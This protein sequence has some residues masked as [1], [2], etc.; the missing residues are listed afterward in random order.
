MYE[1]HLL[2]RQGFTQKE[3][4]QKLDVSDRTVRNYLS[5][6]PCRRKKAARCSKLS[7]FQ[8][9]IQSVIKDNPFF[10]NILLFQKIQAMGY[11][12]KLTI[13][14]VY[15]KKIRDEIL[16]QAVIRFE[17]EPGFQAQVDWKEFGKKLIDGK[18]IKLYAFVMILGFSRKKFVCFT[19]SMKQSLLLQAHIQ[20][21]QWFG[22]IPQEILYDNMKTAFC[23]N[24]EKEFKPNR[25]LLAFAHH[26]GFTPK[27]CRVR[28]PQTKGK[29]ERAIEYLSGNFM[30]GLSSEYL[31]IDSLNEQVIE[32]LKL[33]EKK[34]L[35]DF[36]ET[37]EVRFERE[38]NFLLKLPEHHHDV[39]EVLESR[40]N[41]ESLVS[42]NGNLYSVPPRFIGKY[43]TLKV[44]YLY[45]HIEIFDGTDS[46]KKVKLITQE[47]NKK[48]WDAQDRNQV[49]EMWEKQNQKKKKQADQNITSIKRIAESVIVRHPSFYENL[50]E[51]E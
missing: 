3:I 34:P 48:V 20:A 11:T 13:L 44:D 47:K 32:W 39:R 23:L 7:H 50:I 25:K 1:A 51:G 49:Q 43:L 21:F 16:T 15:V 12:G 28:R 38:K 42:C 26:Y 17:T 35:R 30:E 19:T 46:I 22:G 29:V 40:V 18:L 10:N 14:R 6:K 5:M 37:R 45:E 41:R 2:K 33:I 4:A 27:R 36:G 24:A 31:S 9:Y 8:P